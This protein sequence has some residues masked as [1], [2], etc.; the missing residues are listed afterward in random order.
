MVRGNDQTKR[1]NNATKPCVKVVRGNDQTIKEGDSLKEQ[2]GVNSMQSV[3]IVAP[4]QWRHLI[5]IEYIRH[6]ATCCVDAQRSHVS[7][8]AVNNMA[9]KGLELLTNTH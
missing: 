5:G 8:N 1:Q 2:C 9:D 7:F 4:V 3:V 6:C